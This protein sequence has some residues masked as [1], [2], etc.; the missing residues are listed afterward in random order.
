VNRICVVPRRKL[1]YLS[2]GAVLAGISLTALT[3]GFFGKALAQNLPAAQVSGEALVLAVDDFENNRSEVRYFVRDEKT[4]VA[5]SLQFSGAPPENFR[6]GARVTARGAQEGDHLN[7]SGSD[8]NIEGTGAAGAAGAA[9][10]QPSP[11]TETES[12]ALASSAATTSITNTS[13][14]MV[15]AQK[16]IVILVNFRNAAIPCTR[17]GCSSAVF[18]AANSVQ[19]LY[20]ETSYGHVSYSGTTV[21]PFTISASNTDACPSPY[22]PTLDTWAAQA[23]AQ[24]TKAGINLTG[25]TEKVYL[26][27]PTS[28][29]GGFKGYST[30][31]GSPGMAFVFACQYTDLIAH[32]MGHNLGM[33]HSSTPSSEYGDY[34]DIM[35]I[36]L[37]ALRDLDAPHRVEFGW[38]P[39]AHLRTVTA[40]GTYTIAPLESNPAVTSLPQALRIYAPSAKAY[41][42]FSFRQPLGYDSVLPKFSS[43]LY[44]NGVS[45]HRWTGSNAHTYFLKGLTDGTSFVDTT[46]HITV[47]QVKHAAGGATV[48]V[49]LG[50]ATATV[51]Q[52]SLSFTNETVGAG[53]AAQ[54]A[55]FSNTGGD[56]MTIYSVGIT[57]ANNQDF[58]VV[59][60]TCGAVLE[61]GTSCTVSVRFKPIKS[62]TRSAFVA[63]ATETGTQ[64]VSLT[65][66]GQ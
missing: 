34:S 10:L 38:L 27:P 22:L 49:S 45:V 50:S 13:S 60:K 21:G 63:L 9:D 14:G 23:D 42:Y 26:L 5:H 24:A 29:C 56:A 31:G 59:S 28:R 55:T 6:T 58:Q 43:G 61:A 51:A 40:G 12:S 1:P 18:A 39:S 36:S 7:V 20:K 15:I 47:K 44:T 41:Y 46:N 48:S 2:L 32:E 62:G 53:G 64:E 66:A 33:N 17:L 52:P 37:L 57:G 3:N 25:Y 65:G 8:V 54:T 19:A 4:G 11:G 16:T 35:G 30:I